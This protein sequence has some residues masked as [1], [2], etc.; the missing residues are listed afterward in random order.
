MFQVFL[1]RSNRENTLQIPLVGDFVGALCTWD[2]CG[3]CQILCTQ[4]N[5]KEFA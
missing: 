2:F 3:S 4:T 5:L 1:V